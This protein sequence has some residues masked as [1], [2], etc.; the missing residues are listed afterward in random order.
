MVMTWMHRGDLTTK[1]KTIYDF[2]QH[3]DGLILTLI[4][5]CLMMR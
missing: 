4:P 2:K 5:R 3:S 1:M